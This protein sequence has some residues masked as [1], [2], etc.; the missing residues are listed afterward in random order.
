MD[1]TQVNADGSTKVIPWTPAKNAPV[2]CFYVY[3]TISADPGSN[4]D[5]NPSPEQ[6]GYAARNQVARLGEQCRVFAPVYRQVTLA[7][8]TGKASPDAWD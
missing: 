5:L 3:P 2:D 4:S 6:E 7:G 8:L 1:A